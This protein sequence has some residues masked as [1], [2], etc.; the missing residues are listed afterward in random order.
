MEARRGYG[1][2]RELMQCGFCGCGYAE[3][4]G[5]ELRAAFAGAVLQPWWLGKIDKRGAR[6]Y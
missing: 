4:F 1:A 2:K 3:I 5:G 6:M